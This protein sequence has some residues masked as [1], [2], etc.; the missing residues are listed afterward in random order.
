M[1]LPTLLKKL[2]NKNG[3]YKGVISSPIRYAGGKSKAVGLI[4]EHLPSNV[5]KIVSPFFGG[6]SFELCVS[7]QLGI[8]VI[9]YDVFD[10]L[11]NFWNILINDKD[12]FLRELSTF[13]I[14]HEEFTKNRHILLHHWE[15][16]KPH[17]LTYHT[18][19]VVELTDAEQGLLTNNKLL[20][21]VYYYYNMSLSYGPM[22]LGWGSSNEINKDKFARR[23]NKLKTL[24]LKNLSIKTLDFQQAIKNH[25]DDFLFLDPPY[26]LGGSSKMFKGIYPNSNFAVHH[27]NFPHDELLKLLKNH[28]GGFILTYNDCKEIREMYKD[29]QQFFPE[30]KYS[31]GQGETRI[32]K[33]REGTNHIKK[34]HEILIVKMRSNAEI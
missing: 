5:K 24:N 7:Q 30:W 19:K 3:T 11:T 32:G 9:G 22:F 8:E 10:M 18:K 16:I 31:Y 12:N 25:P 27:N 15:T 6:G 1:D 14:T 33:N 34:S 28:Q 2:K 26:Y 21:A 20:Q 29:Y 23:L 13:E 4:L 17:D